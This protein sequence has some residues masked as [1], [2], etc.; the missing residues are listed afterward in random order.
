MLSKLLTRDSG[1]LILAT[2][3]DFVEYVKQRKAAIR[4]ELA[5]LETAER[6]YKQSGATGGNPTLPLHM[7]ASVDKPTIQ[8]GVIQLLEETYPMGLTT[9][10]I[11]D[12]LN[13]RWWRGELRRTSLSPQISRLKKD[14]KVVSEQGAWKLLKESAPPM[15]FGG[16]SRSSGAVPERSKGPDLQSGKPASPGFVGSNPTGT[17]Y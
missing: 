11:L 15:V 10:G 12:R 1:A 14:R 6:I 5:E 16:A 7:G 4:K 3:D 13:R 2:M 17:A 8:E 9:L